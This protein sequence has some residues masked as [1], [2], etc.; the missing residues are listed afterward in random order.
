MKTLL[1]KLL[2][3]MLIASP[4]VADA[5]ADAIEHLLL[6]VGDSGCTFIRNGKE[7]TSD[8][9]E[10]HLRMK[11]RRGK[12]WAPDAEAFI[13]RIASKSS[14]SGKPYRIRCGTDPAE[15]TSEW[16]TLRL[17]EHSASQP[18]S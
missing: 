11:Y 12:K 6:A 9:A 13:K 7:Y 10:D 2:L 5:E 8:D 14:V 18:R 4:A 17:A 1:P 3:S 15:L 16:L